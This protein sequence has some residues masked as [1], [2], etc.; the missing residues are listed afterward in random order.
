LFQLEGAFDVLPAFPVAVR[1][2]LVLKPGPVV[3]ELSLP[4]F[5][6]TLYALTALPDRVTVLV[7]AV[8]ATGEVLVQQY[9]F[10][11]LGH[12]EVEAGNP[13]G[14]EHLCKLEVAQSYYTNFSTAPYQLVLRELLSGKW[15]DP[16]LGCLAGYSLI[17]AGK[18]DRYSDPEGGGVMNKLWCPTEL[19][20]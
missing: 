2:G 8:K 5:D 20:K 9:L 16:L 7:V 6:R 18:A 13:R 11:L 3:A 10:A 17:R 12:L 19:D 4:G 14:G 15:L 1:R